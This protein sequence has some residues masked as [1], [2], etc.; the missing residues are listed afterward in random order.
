MRINILTAFPQVFESPFA[1]GLIKI[2]QN[3]NL[4][5]L[6]IYD[7]RRFAE[8]KRK[9]I[10]D[11]PFGGGPGM[12][13]KI[14]PIDKAIKHIRKE[15]A[16]IP[17]TLVFSPQGILLNQK[18]AASFAKE[19]SLILICGHYEG[20]DER[21]V[22][23]LSQIEV[24]VGDYILSG[25]EIPALLT[26]DAICRL[27]PGVLGNPSSLTSESFSTSGGPRFD[28]PQYAKPRRYQK[29]SVPGILL[30]GDHE[31]IDDWREKKANRKL[32]RNRPDLP[33]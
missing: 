23:H 9:T 2:A 33:R 8:D 13:L 1:H 17:K 27:I 32:R 26:V 21:V 25:G 5:D 16:D 4:V 3:K 24:S 15:C 12:V 29:W 7:L 11:R 28:H 22:S 6:R 20:I 19:A 31:K 18:L 14:G 10:D 30:S